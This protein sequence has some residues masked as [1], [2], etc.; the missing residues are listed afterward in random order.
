MLHNRSRIYMYM[1][2]FFIEY[3]S[4]SLTSVKL[5]LKD[6]LLNELT[7]NASIFTRF[8]ML[9][10]VHDSLFSANISNLMYL[11][12]IHIHFW[13][14]YTLMLRSKQYL[15]LNSM[16]AVDVGSSFTISKS[17]YLI[18]HVR[19]LIFTFI[20]NFIRLPDLHVLKVSQRWS[21]YQ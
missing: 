9:V 16:Y 5:V 10:F 2:I 20:V 7:F 3:S 4:P 12:S 14:F 15:Q 21:Q 6:S 18:T 1:H 17:Y 11:H 19:Y 8:D 13:I